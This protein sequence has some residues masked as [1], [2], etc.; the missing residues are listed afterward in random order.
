MKRLKKT[1]LTAAYQN[2]EDTQV[3]FR[4]LVA[5]PLLPVVDIVPG[6]EEVKA[7]VKPD[8][9]LQPQLLQLCGYVERQ[10]ISKASIHVGAAKLSVRDNT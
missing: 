5:L 6:F 9:A 10:W 1:G 7:L 3:V 4:C 2:E 8:S